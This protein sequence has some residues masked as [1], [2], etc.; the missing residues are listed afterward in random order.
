MD[1][2]SP[3][4]V[5]SASRGIMFR[6]ILL[7]FAVLLLTAAQTYAQTPIEKLIIKYGNINGAKEIS[8][9]G[10]QMAIAR[11][12]MKHTPVAPVAG[13]VDK[14]Y[15]LKMAGVSDEILDKFESDLQKVL[16]SYEYYGTQE[17]PKGKVDVYVMR[18]GTSIIKELVVYNPENHTL[19]SFYGT[20]PLDVLMKMVKE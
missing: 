3:A 15:I 8:A 9:S 5:T 6:R 11:V 12:M 20:F 7:L 16:K 19:N 1:N 14:V 18:S 2:D 4:A 10:G 13:D 17:E